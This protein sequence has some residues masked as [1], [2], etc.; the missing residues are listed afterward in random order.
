MFWRTSLVQIKLGYKP[1]KGYKVSLGYRYNLRTY[2]N[3]HRLQLDNSYQKK[4]GKSTAQIRLRVQYAQSHGLYL[5]EFRFRPRF[6]Y[7]FKWSK[8]WRTFASIE[9]FYTG[10]IGSYK[11]DQMRYSFGLGRKIKKGHFAQL[12]YMIN[13][14]YNREYRLNKYVLALKYKIDL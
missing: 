14:E 3:T 6:K 1:F 10:I 11:F 4:I 9:S 8:K 5:Q 12:L 13:N 7:T 2:F